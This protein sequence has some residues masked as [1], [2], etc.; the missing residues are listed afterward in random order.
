M[1]RPLFEQSFTALG[2]E[3]GIE[4]DLVGTVEYLGTLVIEHL[5]Q[6]TETVTD[7]PGRVL[8]QFIEAVPLDDT[9][10]FFSQI[11]SHQLVHRLFDDMLDV[12]FGI[13]AGTGMEHTRQ[14]A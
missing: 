12:Q 5:R 7:I 4:D 8:R 1:L 11:G 9:Q 14:A 13:G 3:S 6:F 2:D 10:V